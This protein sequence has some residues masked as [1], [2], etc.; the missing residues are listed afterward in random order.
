MEIEYSVHVHLKERRKIRSAN[1]VQLLRG[2]ERLVD[3]E[4][5]SLDVRLRGQVPRD[6]LDRFTHLTNLPGSTNGSSIWDIVESATF[7]FTTTEV[8]PFELWD[9]L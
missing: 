6:H 3:K 5:E 9:L 7:D 4:S 2:N 1:E 8:E